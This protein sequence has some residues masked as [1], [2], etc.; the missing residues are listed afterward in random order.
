MLRDPLVCTV[1]TSLL[2]NL[3][4]S[5]NQEL[6]KAL[7]SRDPAMIARFM[8]KESPDVRMLGA[9]INSVN[10]ILSSKRLDERKN[11]YLL[12]SDT[13]DGHFIGRVLE[14]YFQSGPL[15]FKNIDR[16]TVQGLTDQD[17]QKFRTEGLRDLVRRVA[18]IVWS[19]GHNR[20]LINATGGYKAQISFAGMIGQA[21]DMPVCYMFE[22][23]SEV[24]E[25]PPQPIALDFSFWLQYVDLFYELAK[26]E[27]LENPASRDP[28][29]QSL[30]DIEPVNGS[31][32]IGLSPVG[33]LFHESFRHRF[34]TQRKKLLPPEYDIKPENKDI[35]YEDSNSG[36]HTGLDKHLNRLVQRSYVKRI[37]TH[38]YNPDLPKPN[39]FKASTKGG[40]SQIEGVYSDGKGTTKFDVV[41]TA[42]SAKE[43]DA[44]IADLYE[45]I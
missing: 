15:A 7:Q 10:S 37:Y 17:P 42:G 29:F 6:Q 16:L 20:I 34:A 22:G 24:I 4:N 3:K 43:R 21:L 5:E 12:C 31:E 30:V 13:E 9:E 8:G 27:A 19:V 2:G 26:D 35:K 18:D 28:R 45:A 39:S 11:L 33:Q 23:F 1:G 32:I 41:I 44:A 40:V 14:K 36:K 38:Y 25:L